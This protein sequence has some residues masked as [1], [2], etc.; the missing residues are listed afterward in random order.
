MS[1]SALNPALEQANNKPLNKGKVSWRRT[2]PYFHAD[3]SGL[4]ASPGLVT[5][6]IRQSQGHEVGLI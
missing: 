3:D 6:G 1:M 2:H 4:L 5:V